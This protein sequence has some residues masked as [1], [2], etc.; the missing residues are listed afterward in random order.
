MTL[1]THCTEHVGCDITPED[2]YRE[3]AG[4][5]DRHREIMIEHGYWKP[6]VRPLSADEQAW[7]R[8]VSE[9]VDPDWNPEAAS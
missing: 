9:F 7:Q 4:D 6:P 5:P 1:W 2:M 8:F 3:A